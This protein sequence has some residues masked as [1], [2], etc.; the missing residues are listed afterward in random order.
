MI[1]VC[2]AGVTGWTGLRRRR[3]GR[4]R[5]RPRARRRRLALRPGSHSSVA[6]AL[7]AAAADVLVDYTHAAAVKDNV[8]GGARARRRRRHRLERPAAADYEEVDAAARA[9]AS[10]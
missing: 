2:V 9:R 10:A 4:G 1:R 7:D 5:G 6:E 3:G 8:L